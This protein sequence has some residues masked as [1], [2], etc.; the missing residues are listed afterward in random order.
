MCLFINIKGSLQN[1]SNPCV[2]GILNTTPDSF[3]DGGRL[4]TIDAIEQ[5]IIQYISEGAAII[6]IGAVSSRPGA[7]LPD[8]KEEWNRLLPT[9]NILYKFHSKIIFSLDTFRASIAS[10]A[11]L[12]FG[13]DII[14][15][16]TAGRLDCNMFETIARL[17]VPYIIMHMQGLPETMQLNPDYKNLINEM[18]LFFTEKINSLH[19]LGIHDI[20]VDPGF[21][22]GKTIQHN[23]QLLSQ[24]EIFKLL[25]MPILVGLSRKSMIYKTLDKNPQEA[26]NGTSVLHAVAL[27]HGAN[28]LRV[29][30][31]KEAVE[32]VRLMHQLNGDMN[33]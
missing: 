16:I 27:L 21:G 18:I 5:K 6:D 14:N 24:L 22:F 11:V 1:V 7:T 23:F 31:V 2:M 9:L 26:L 33:F 8:E 13:V 4:H 17:D 29:H 3:Y 28:I 25:E 20:I 32:A 15:D 30:D 10:R 12:N 19:R